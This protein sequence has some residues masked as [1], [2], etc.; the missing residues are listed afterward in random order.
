MSHRFKRSKPLG[1]SKQSMKNE[2]DE[3]QKQLKAAQ[4]L[5]EGSLYDFLYVDRARVS[6]LYAQLFPEGTLTSVKKTA[7][8]ISSEDDNIGSDIKIFKAE[9]KSSN[10]ASEG[11][12]HIFDPSWAVPLD[13]LLELETRASVK[14]LL[15][16]LPLGAV[17]KLKGYLRIID[18]SSMKELWEP[19]LSLLG[20]S[21]KPEFQGLA[22]LMKGLPHGLH[23]HFIS[24][25]AFSW[26]SLIASGLMIPS[27]DITL[28][29]GGLVS[30]EWEML[31]ILDAHP[32]EG[33]APDFA[34]WSAGE[35]T[36]GI[37]TLMH[38]LRLQ[39]GRPPGWHGVTPLMIYRAIP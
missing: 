12:E 19:V 28:K 8:Q 15:R 1:K 21:D 14:P 25:D 4:D 9:A 26:S 13:V 37:L 36:N 6:S 35:A 7:N 11:I 3:P 32:D 27:T 30:G 23:A 31:A 20:G 18:Y 5:A 17:A 29:H 2:K 38:S 34:N 10:S 24:A 16:G 33:D 22:G 39:I